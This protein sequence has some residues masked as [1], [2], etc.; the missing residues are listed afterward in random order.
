MITHAGNPTAVITNGPKPIRPRGRPSLLARAVSDR[1]AGKAHTKTPAAKYLAT[2][3]ASPDAHQVKP[4]QKA[5]AISC[6]SIADEMIVATSEQTHEITYRSLT[7]GSGTCSL[8]AR[9]APRRRRAGRRWSSVPWSWLI[10]PVSRW[11]QLTTAAYGQTPSPG[12]RSLKWPCR[13]VDSAEVAAGPR[14]SA[15]RVQAV[16][17]SNA[18]GGTGVL[19]RRKIPPS[20]WP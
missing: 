7:I 17:R 6:I 19:A 20:W 3:A 8:S 11:Y 15:A 10:P 13:F 18:G 2:H 14:R 4:P 9:A 5:A 1:T 16:V 12:P